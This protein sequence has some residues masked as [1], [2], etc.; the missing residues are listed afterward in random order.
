V[1]PWQR[2]AGAQSARVQQH[3]VEPPRDLG[4]VAFGEPLTVEAS[5]SK[6]QSSRGRRSA[7]SVEPR[8]AA[9]KRLIARW[10]SNSTV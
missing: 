10:C 3:L 9:L 7:S 8:S 6:P 5:P 1:P 4:P 2:R